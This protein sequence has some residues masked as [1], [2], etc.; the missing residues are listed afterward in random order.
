[1]SITKALL[2]GFTITVLLIVSTWYVGHLWVFIFLVTSAFIGI[3]VS[4][5]KESKK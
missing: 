4:A 5:I 3:A 2:C 1:M